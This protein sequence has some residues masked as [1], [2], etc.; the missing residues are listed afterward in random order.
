MKAFFTIFGFIAL[1][2]SGIH[3]TIAQETIKKEV[4]N[5]KYQEFTP[6]FVAKKQTESLQQHLSL[7]GAQ[8][9][10]V[11]EVLLD[12]EQKMET[13]MSTGNSESVK[14]AEIQKMEDLKTQKLKEIFTSDQFTKYLEIFKSNKR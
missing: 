2:S 1:F 13:F 9:L 6:E 12:I 11:Q 10:R 5:V 7:D 3:S 8:V 4:A 14:M